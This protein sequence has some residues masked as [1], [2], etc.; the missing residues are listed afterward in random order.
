MQV[1]ASRASDNSID[2][3][4]GCIPHA[5]SPGLSPS[6]CGTGADLSA[7]PNGLARRLTWRHPPSHGPRELRTV[8]APN[9][10]SEWLREL[11]GGAAHDRMRAKARGAEP[12][13]VPTIAAAVRARRRGSPI[14]ARP[15]PWSGKPTCA[16]STGTRMPRQLDRRKEKPQR[17]GKP[18]GRGGR[19][20]RWVCLAYSPTTRR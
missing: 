17:P 15:A 2:G 9:V 12:L 7:P 18:L 6:R 4:R 11:A 3:R 1:E 13:L 20:W 10:V 19:S 14:N 5:R 8:S 16:G